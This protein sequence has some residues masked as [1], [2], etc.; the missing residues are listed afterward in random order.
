MRLDELLMRCCEENEILVIY[1]GGTMFASQVSV[2]RSGRG[3]QGEQAMGLIYL[4]S[5][6][7]IFGASTQENPSAS[8][9]DAM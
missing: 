7:Q 5:L 3:Y 8:V 2:Q 1:L 9:I 6:V 4:T